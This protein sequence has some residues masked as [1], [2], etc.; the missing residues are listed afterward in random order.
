VCREKLQIKD[1]SGAYLKTACMV[2]GN[3][4][5][6]NGMN[7]FVIESEAEQT[8][9]LDYS[10]TYFPGGDA[11]LWINGQKDANGVWSTSNP[12][13]PLFSGIKWKTNPPTEPGNCLI[14]RNTA[15]ETE[16]YIHPVECGL[17]YWSYCEYK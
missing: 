14:V 3:D 4:C 5:Q 15:S 2:A 8:Q 1:T 12:T 11:S 17:L 7:F 9:L 13:L 16:F 6:A 10:A